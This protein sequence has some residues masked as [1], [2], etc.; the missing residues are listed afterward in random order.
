M[1]NAK[2]LVPSEY[3]DLAN[4]MADVAGAVVLSYFRKK[5][6]IED[7]KDASPVTI[8]DRQSEAI[9]RELISQHAPEHGILGEEYGPE[10]LDAEWVWVLDPIDGTKAFITGKPSFGILIALL[11]MGKPVL[12]V[13]DQPVTAER[14]LGAAGRPTT[15]NGE[16]V[17]CRPCGD[18]SKAYLYATTPD[19]FHGRDV[20]SWEKLRGAV[21]LA[22]YGA[23]CYAAGLLASGFV[24][25]MVEASLQ[26]YDY[27]PLVPVIEGAGGIVTDWDGERLGLH[28]DGRICAAGDARAHQAA[29][30][31]LNP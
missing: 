30:A 9:M 12:G 31:L 15:L 24:D 10:R 3:V 21:K 19:M 25:L 20:A 27:L 18:L 8:A 16:R 11:H 4:R 6:E 26:P 23:D 28:S 2:V 29:L 17:L 5:V 7:K 14:W 13:I 22:R 1:G